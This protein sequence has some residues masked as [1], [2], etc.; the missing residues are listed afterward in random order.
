MDS[1]CAI[2]LL[3]YLKSKEHETVCNKLHRSLTSRFHQNIVSHC[4]LST[5]YSTHNWSTNDALQDIGERWSERPCYSC[6]FCRKPAS[7][8]NMLINADLRTHFSCTQSESVFF[9]IPPGFIYILKFERHSTRSVAFILGCTL[10][11]SGEHY[12]KKKKGCLIPTL[13][14]TYTG[15]G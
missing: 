5:Y 12:E 8:S 4:L 14:P 10:K 9:K 13:L 3:V 15:F 7:P 1:L 11:S 6:V 2:W